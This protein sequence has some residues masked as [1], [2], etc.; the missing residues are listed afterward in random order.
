[1]LVLEHGLF[2]PSSAWVSDSGRLL[3]I[4]PS[5][6]AREII[7]DGLTRPVAV[8]IWDDRQLIVSELGGSL[9]F[10]TRNP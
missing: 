3:R 9:Y 1:M 6:G 7:L 4:K 5:T 2:D 8:L 10:L